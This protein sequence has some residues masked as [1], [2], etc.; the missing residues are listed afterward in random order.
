MNNSVKNVGFILLKYTPSNGVF[1]KCRKNKQSECIN[2]PEDVERQHKQN[3]VRSVFKK[4]IC[5]IT[6][7]GSN[8]VSPN[9]S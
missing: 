8:V 7:R 5:G 6:Y 4:I 9:I 3:Q 2:I 1:G